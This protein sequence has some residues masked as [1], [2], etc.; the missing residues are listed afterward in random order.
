VHT[1]APLATLLRIFDDR[2]EHGS[3]PL[4]QRRWKHNERNSDYQ[5]DHKLQNHRCIPDRL[6]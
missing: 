4:R 2:R 6:E 5:R 1:P 3:T